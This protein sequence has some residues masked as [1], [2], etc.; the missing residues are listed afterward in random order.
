MK[1]TTASSVVQS[2]EEKEKE[3]LRAEREK[4]EYERLRE[5]RRKERARLEAIGE[6]R[7]RLKQQL[8]K[9]YL[10][11][12]EK[13]QLTPVANTEPLYDV[14]RTIVLYSPVIQK[15]KPLIDNNVWNT[16]FF[17]PYL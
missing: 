16:S 6:S 5:E 14:V 10:F 7:K 3:R 13:T 15:W 2:P 11:D 8:M 17:C 9:M 12:C 4:E 1:V